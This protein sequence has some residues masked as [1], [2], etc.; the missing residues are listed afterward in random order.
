M[1]TISILHQALWFAHLSFNLMIPFWSCF[2]FRLPK[3]LLDSHTNKIDRPPLQQLPH[4]ENVCWCAGKKRLIGERE[5][6]RDHPSAIKTVSPSLIPLPCT[7]L[8]SIITRERARSTCLSELW[9]G[10]CGYHRPNNQRLLHI[11]I[12]FLFRVLNYFLRTHPNVL[13]EP[14]WRHPLARVS[15]HPTFVIIPID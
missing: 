8:H 12:Y 3:W 5:G 14:A 13:R 1:R 7:M 10:E 6:A 11:R 2:I 9:G 4:V 15:T